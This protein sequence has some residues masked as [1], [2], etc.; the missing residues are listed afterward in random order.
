MCDLVHSHGG[1]VYVDGANLNALVGVARPGVVRR[2]RQPPEPAQDLLH[3]PW[4][5]RPG[6]GP[7]GRARA[8]G[9]VPPEPPPAA[10]GGPGHR[11]RTHLRGALRLRVDPA[12]LVGLHRA[13]GPR[14]A[15]P[16]HRAGDPQRQLRRRP[17]RRRLPRAL[18]RR[19]RPRGPRVHPRPAPDH[20]RHRRHRR[21]RRQAPHRLRLPRAHH[22]LP[23]GRHPHGRADG[24]RVARRARPLRRRHARHPRG[25]RPDR[26]G[27]GGPRRQRP[28]PRPAHRRGR[29][30]R[31]L[32]PA[33]TRA[34][35]PPIPLHSLRD[36]KYWPPVSRIDGG[37]GDRN[38]VCAC[39]PPEAYET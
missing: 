29:A 7:G 2:R 8:P 20:R 30:G 5:R 11:A 26:A 1:Q 22:E 36:G 4:R 33:R 39:P 27:R 25:D 18:H 34:S 28:R 3:P 6:R 37:Y 19:P 17:P 21:R 23:G 10:R 15:A 24:V 9:A 16:G 12:D 14:R 38:L 31:R 35:R 32:G 13:D